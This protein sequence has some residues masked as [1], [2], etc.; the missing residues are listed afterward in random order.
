M[1]QPK[2]LIVEDEAP[3]RQMI[4]FNLSRAGFSVDEAGDVASARNQIANKQLRIPIPVIIQPGA[5]ALQRMAG[6]W[7]TAMER[8][9]PW[10]N[11]FDAL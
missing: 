3:V 9:R 11:A 6:P 8:V 4:A 2:V 7:S 10:T 1:S 5:M